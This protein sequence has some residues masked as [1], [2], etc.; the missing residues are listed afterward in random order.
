MYESDVDAMCCVTHSAARPRVLRT[1]RA[2]HRTSSDQTSFDLWT[3]CQST[4]A[5]LEAF[6]R[7][8]R[9]VL[10][11]KLLQNATT[12]SV[13]L[14][15]REFRRRLGFLVFQPTCGLKCVCLCVACMS[16]CWYY[17][18]PIIRRIRY[19]SKAFLECNVVKEHILTK[20]TNCRVKSEQGTSGVAT[21]YNTKTVNV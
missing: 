3:V 18:G 19:F 8:W 2:T 4:K 21:D 7:N 17:W 12:Y 5:G 1:S 15:Q 16:G 14:E 13:Y 9:R 6:W 20:Y 10:R 11:D